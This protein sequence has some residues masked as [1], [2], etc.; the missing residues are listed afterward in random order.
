[1]E[2]LTKALQHGAVLASMATVMESVSPIGECNSVASAGLT[3]RILDRTVCKVAMR[4]ELIPITSDF[5]GLRSRP[6]IPASFS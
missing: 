4:S 5:W 2:S 3:T 6:T 1:M